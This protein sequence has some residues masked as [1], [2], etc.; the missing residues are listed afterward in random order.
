MWLDY[1]CLAYPHRLYCFLCNCDSNFQFQFSSLL[2]NS[3]S[4]QR[5][6][7]PISNVFIYFSKL[8]CAVASRADRHGL[9]VTPRSCRWRCSGAKWQQMCADMRRRWKRPIFS[10]LP[11][12]P[13]GE[14]SSASVCLLALIFRNHCA[15]ITHLA[16]RHSYNTPHRKH[17]RLTGKCV[18]VSVCAPAC[19]CVSNIN[20]T[21]SER[22]T[23]TAE[24]SPWQCDYWTGAP[25]RKSG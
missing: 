4:F 17:F 15:G 1:Q 10:R 11:A 19:V 6:T 21:S 23:P 12:F 13:C 24:V 3:N 8:S 14:N 22:S 9:W 7:D 16:S 20:R 2:L 18:T 25:E 5:N